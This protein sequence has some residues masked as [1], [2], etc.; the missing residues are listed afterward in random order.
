MA[1]H[2]LVPPGE[3]QSAGMCGPRTAFA[4]LPAAI[5]HVTQS[6]PHVFGGKDS[7]VAAC[8]GGPSPECG[9]P[10]ADREHRGST[11]APEGRQEGGLLPSPLSSNLSGLGPGTRHP[12]SVSKRR[13]AGWCVAAAPS[14][15]HPDKGGLM[16]APDVPSPTAPP[17]PVPHASTSSPMPPLLPPEAPRFSWAGL[18]LSLP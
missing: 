16:T 12:L 4:K 2:L 5:S 18:R 14:S 3:G 15:R 11:G 10:V 9:S 7:L 6:V 13:W 8:L 17:G 1:I